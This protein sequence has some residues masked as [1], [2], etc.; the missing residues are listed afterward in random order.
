MK[1]E[2]S[3]LIIDD[4]P[5]S[6]TQAVQVLE[7][8][9]ES[10]GFSLR[11]QEETNFSDE[12]LRHLAR[13]EGRNYDLVVIDYDLGKQKT[14]GAD[15]ASRLRR[16]LKYTDMIFYSSISTPA[17]LNRKLIDQEV[18][19]VFA[20][21]RSNLD[22]ALTGLANTVIGK[23]VDLNHMRG[24]AMAEVS[25][26]DFLMEKTLQY[27][28]ESENSDVAFVRKRTVQRLKESLEEGSKFLDGI[29]K[30][31]EIISLVGDSRIFSSANKFH[32]IQR[33][34]KK[35]SE[36][37]HN[38]LEKLNSYQ[39]DIIENRN[40]LAHVKEEIENGKTVLRSVGRDGKSVLID[41]DWMAGFR[42]KLK[43]HR[44]AL[45]TVCEALKSQFGIP[46]TGQESE[47]DQA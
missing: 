23:A 28:F 1:L 11:K 6:I 31:E 46:E 22:I 7:D 45:T 35:L 2:F 19:G 24:I 25:E 8:H 20:E 43:A 18:S 41:D 27:V 37:P 44:F 26:M 29:C 3:L 36:A 40:M 15:I 47:K 34:S 42:R 33:M 10:K 32:A 4:A 21:S 13:V 30:K 14:D 38:S 9:L 5:D 17:E 12:N 39:I 16:S